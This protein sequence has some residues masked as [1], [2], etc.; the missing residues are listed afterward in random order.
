VYSYVAAAAQI[1]FAM[2]QWIGELLYVAFSEHQNSEGCHVLL[3]VLLGCREKVPALLQKLRLG[4]DSMAV[5][6]TPR[7]LA[8]V[9][10]GLAAKQTPQTSRLRGPP[11]KAAFDKEG[12]ATKALEG[13]CR[14]VCWV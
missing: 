3:L 9:V 12:K 11:A 1:V 7:R 2:W 5:H 8:V 6:G 4:Y 14:W 13:F 10:S